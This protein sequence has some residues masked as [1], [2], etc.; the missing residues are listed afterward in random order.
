MKCVIRLLCEGKLLSSKKIPERI[1][2]KD[3][4]DRCSIIMTRQMLLTFLNAISGVIYVRIYRF[5]GMTTQLVAAD[6]KTSRYTS[7]SADKARF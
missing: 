1:S 3:I 6:I 5:G 7:Y 4:S 2:K